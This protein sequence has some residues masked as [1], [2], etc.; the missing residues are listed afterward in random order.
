M[1]VA[2]G[3]LMTLTSGDLMTHDVLRV[4]AAWPIT[5]LV[6]FLGEHGISGAPVVSED[7]RLVGV[8]SL[9]DVARSG[10]PAVKPRRAPPSPDAHD[11]YRFGP[12]FTAT[13]PIYRALNS[14]LGTGT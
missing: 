11:F 9:T 12:A 5:R 1:D 10:G 2:R 7:G 6:A 4:N 13:K 14:R 3:N 8:V